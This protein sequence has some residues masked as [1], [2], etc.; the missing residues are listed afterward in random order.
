[1]KTIGFLLALL[2]C[3]L[4]YGQENEENRNLVFDSV[5]PASPK[6]GLHDAS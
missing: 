4:S 3:H 5:D 1:M 2:T 6:P